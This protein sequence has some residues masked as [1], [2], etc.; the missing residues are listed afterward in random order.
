MGHGYLPPADEGCRRAAALDRS[1]RGQENGNEG[2]ADVLVGFRAFLDC[3]VLT[4]DV[5][6]M[7]ALTED[8]RAT[9]CIRIEAPTV[10]D[11]R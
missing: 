8:C 7:A 3:A 11:G 6:K 10:P 5:A 4:S 9:C 1:C 2:E